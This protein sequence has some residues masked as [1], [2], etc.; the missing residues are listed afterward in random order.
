MPLY[1]KS[2]MIRIMRNRDNQ[3]K[4][5]RNMNAK[6]PFFWLY[7]NSKKDAVKQTAE[8]AYHEQR[9]RASIYHK[10]LYV[11]KGC[12]LNT[13]VKKVH[14]T[15]S[16]IN[17]SCSTMQEQRWEQD[18]VEKRSCRNYDDRLTLKAG[19]ASGWKTERA[20]IALTRTPIGWAS[21]GIACMI[22]CK[23]WKNGVQET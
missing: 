19:L 13:Y 3:L 15:G 11:T 18:L 6:C 5:Q 23:T 9:E 10:E 17:P 16:I 4:K 14:K 12:I 22:S 2:E 20:L 7:T 21:W 8:Y 1:W